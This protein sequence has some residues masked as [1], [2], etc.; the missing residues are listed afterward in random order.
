VID[1]ERGS[2]SLYSHLVDFDTLELN[3]PFEP[4][5]FREAI[6]A[7]AAAGYEVCIIDSITHEWDGSG[8]CLEINEATAQAKFRG[9]TWAAWNE[10]TPRHRAFIDAILQS[11]MHMIATMRSKTETVQGDDKKV[12]KLGMKAVQREGTEYEFSTVLDL[13]HERHYAVSTKD[14]TGQFLQPHIIS[15]ETGA[16]IKAW[17]ESG[18]VTRLPDS[19]IADFKA[20]IK[21]AADLYQLRMVFEKAYKL[22][23]ASNDFQSEREFA[24]AKDECKDALTPKDPAAEAGAAPD[25]G[26]APETGTAPAGEV[27]GRDQALATME[28]ERKA[29]AEAAGSAEV[30]RPAA[31]TQAKPESAHKRNGKAAQAA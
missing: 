25:A 14:R 15:R 2:A 30:Q 5:R 24:L 7:A 3:P 10:T 17:L 19:Q 21:G 9:N 8:G 6:T 20:E 18:V 13:E 26:A 31:E 28:S 4:E 11:P 16:R 1:T 22:A 27:V 29:T 12:K 23:Q